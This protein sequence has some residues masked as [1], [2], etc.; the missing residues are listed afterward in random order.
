[1][2]N[3]CNLVWVAMEAILLLLYAWNSAPIPG[4]NLS[5]CFVALGREFQIPINFAAN[6]HFKL[7]ST[8]STVMLYSRNLDTCLSTL[9]RWLSSWLKSSPLNITS[10]STHDGQIQ[11][12][13]KSVTWFLLGGLFA[14]TQCGDRLTN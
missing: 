9:P 11:K 5:H 7:T 12:S 2:T 3:K 6:K 8:L 14:L 1:M 10:L 13:I 4:T